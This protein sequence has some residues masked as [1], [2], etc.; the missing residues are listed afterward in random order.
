VRHLKDGDDAMA[1]T[2]SRLAFQTA[3]DLKRYTLFGVTKRH[4]FPRGCL[5]GARLQPAN[6]RAL[7]AGAG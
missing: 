3:V 5:P 4:Y 2:V 7:H 6:T 1:R